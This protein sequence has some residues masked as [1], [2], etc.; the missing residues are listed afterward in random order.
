MYKKILKKRENSKIKKD[1]DN[2]VLHLYK[3]NVI[4]TILILSVIFLKNKDVFY[5]Q[6]IA[7]FDALYELE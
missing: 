6:K 2:N 1:I 3:K 5:F 4:L 7:K